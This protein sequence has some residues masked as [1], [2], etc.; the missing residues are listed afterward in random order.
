QALEDLGNRFVV[1]YSSRFPHHRG[2][3]LDLLRPF[4]ERL[5]GERTLLTDHFDAS[6]DEKQR[7]VEV[8]R[9]RHGVLRRIRSDLIFFLQPLQALLT[10]SRPRHEQIVTGLVVML[11]WTP[12][13]LA[14]KH[15]HESLKHLA[16]QF[17][18]GC[19][20]RRPH[21]R[22]LVQRIFRPLHQDPSLT[23]RTLCDH[24]PE[25]QGL[26]DVFAL[27]SEPSEGS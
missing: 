3:I 12:R 4:T 2:V 24:V 8:S 16:E 13:R 20:A 6:D 9:W 10:S 23:D 27:W 5:R 22:G 1:E 17:E 21:L 7:A 25:G 14:E 18:A 26:T 11:R 15:C 19:R